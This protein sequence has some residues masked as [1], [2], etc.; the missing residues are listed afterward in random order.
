LQ[1]MGGYRV[2]GTARRGG[3]VSVGIGYDQVNHQ[4][5]QTVPNHIH[6]VIGPSLIA[7]L[8]INF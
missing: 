4:D 7:G 3:T 8:A 6:A 2:W 5:L 1:A